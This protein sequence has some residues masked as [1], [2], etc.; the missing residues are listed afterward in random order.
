MLDEGGRK[1]SEKNFRANPKL[2]ALEQVCVDK[3][4]VE[5]VNLLAVPLIVGV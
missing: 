4:G 3:D 1:Q 2:K 5:V